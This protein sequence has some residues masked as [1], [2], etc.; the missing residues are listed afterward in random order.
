M[1][2]EEHLL[3]SR[4]VCDVEEHATS[5][6]GG[7]AKDEVGIREVEVHRQKRLDGSTRQLGNVFLEAGW[8]RKVRDGGT[9]G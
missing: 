1:E 4:F 5:S 2:G 3:S 8:R 6:H 7:I 9:A